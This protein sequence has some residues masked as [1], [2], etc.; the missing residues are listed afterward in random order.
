MSFHNAT[1]PDIELSVV[2]PCLNEADTLGTCIR[3]ARLAMERAGIVGEVIVAD[4]GSTDDSRAIAAA[5]GARLVPV[6]DRGYGAALMGGIDAAR[7][8]FIVM[9]DADDSYDFG[10]VPAF[11][12]RLREGCDL[13]QGCRLES[14][15]GRVLP[16]AMPRLHRW[17]GNPMFSK[18]ARQWFRAPV[19]D[20][21]C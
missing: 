16:G 6:S 13:V 7:G 17:L 3:K 21:Y 14:G 11:V 20:I 15:G 10:E 8:R 18:I 5:E 2:M 1:H 19:R 12:E 4:N 9:G